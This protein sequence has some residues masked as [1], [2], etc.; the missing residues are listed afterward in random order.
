MSI[1][2]FFFHQGAFLGV[3]F[4]VIVLMYMATH[5]LWNVG[6]I[7]VLVWACIGGLLG[8]VPQLIIDRIFYGK[9][10]CAVC[11][12]VIYNGVNNDSTL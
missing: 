5:L 9:W 6:V 11:N 1:F 10:V 12:I 8:L 4:S 3:P 7:P 2:F